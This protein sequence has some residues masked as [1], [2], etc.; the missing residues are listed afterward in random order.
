MFLDKA[1]VRVG[2]YWFTNIAARSRWL[3]GRAEKSR[4]NII[5]VNRLWL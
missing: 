2:N 1:A 3:L 5:G 4:H